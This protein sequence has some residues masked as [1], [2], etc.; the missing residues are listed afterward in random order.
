MKRLLLLTVL[1]ILFVPFVFNSCDDDK[2][3]LAPEIASINPDRGEI[4]STVTIT[5]SKFATD[6]IVNFNGTQASVTSSSATQ[7]IVTV[8]VNA[9]SGNVTVTNNNKTTTGPVFTV[10]FPPV[11]SSINPLSGMAEDEIIISGSNFSTT[12]S[13]NIVKFNGTTTTVTAASATQLTVTV[14]SGATTGTVT[15]EVNGKTAIGPVFSV[16]PPPVISTVEPASAKVGDEV[17]ITGSNFSTTASENIVKFNGIRASVSSATATTLV[18]VVPE[19]ATTGVLKVNVNGQEVTGPD[20]TIIPPPTISAISPSS[21]KIGDNITITGANFS[22]APSNN[23]VKFNGTPA[24]VTSA[25]ATQ[26]EVSVPS[27]ATTGVITVEVNGMTATSGVFTVL[28]PTISSISPTSGAIGTEVTITGT[29]FHTTASANLV[30]FNGNNATVASASPTQLVV[31][32]PVGATTGAITVSAG[33]ATVTGPV[34][35]V[36]PSVTITNVSIQSGVAG[37]DNITITG[38]G[39]STTAANNVVRVNGVQ[40]DLL[41]NPTATQIVARVPATATSGMITV[42]TNGATANGPNF[43]VLNNEATTTLDN[44]DYTYSV[45]CGF[46]ASSGNYW[47]AASGGF[48][49]PRPS[50]AINFLSPTRPSTAGTYPAEVTAERPGETWTFT[51]TTVDVTFDAQSRMIVTFTNA[52]PSPRAGTTSKA[53]SGVVTIY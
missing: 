25:T 52:M 6:A 7:L 3:T 44:V 47:I 40:A 36:T 16:I 37:C 51:P 35:T 32:V 14:P 34:F 21:G 10:E 50:F 18:V 20:F 9:T 53:F 33:G 5:G 11:I 12:G 49:S 1:C 39:F 8:P 38:T 17:T 22:I 2:E 24:T 27:G 13:Q 48:T 31:S 29:N 41:P 43:T 42:T 28:Q 26:L 46:A 15:V 23:I 45:V 19:G 30:A 4:G